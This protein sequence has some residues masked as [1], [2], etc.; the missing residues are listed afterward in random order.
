MSQLRPVPAARHSSHATFIHR[1]LKDAT[2]VFLRQD[3][4]RRALAPPY[5]GPHKVITRT[6]KTFQLSVRGRPV[7]VSADRV[8][9][10]YTVNET[11][12]GI[13]TAKSQLSLVP[14]AASAPDPP[15]ATRTTRA[16]RS[17]RLPARFNT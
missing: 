17:V 6:D 10:A 8:K 4:L 5:S 16:G 3:A 15:P 1:D 14:L 7:T 9:P 11:E 2:H 13:S 12:R